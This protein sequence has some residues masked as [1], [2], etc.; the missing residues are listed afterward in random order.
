MKKRESVLNINNNNKKKEFVCHNAVGLRRV[1]AGSRHSSQWPQI[2]K[3]RR[4]LHV[5]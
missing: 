4:L 5:A 3:G 1:P 2:Q